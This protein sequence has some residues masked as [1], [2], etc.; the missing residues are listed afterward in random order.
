MLTVMVMLSFVMGGIVTLYISGVRAQTKM[1]D[2]FDAQT[3]LQVGLDRLRKDVHLACTVSTQS[4]SLIQL[5]LSPC[6]NSNEVTWCA[7]GSGSDYGLYRVTSWVSTCTGG[8]KLADFLTSS[9]IFTY[10]APNVT[11][12]TPATGSYALA[13]L[14]VDLTAN[15]V[16][17]DTTTSYHVVD[18]IVFGNSTRCTTGTNCPS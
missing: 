14:H 4:S 16:P 9:S 8:Q 7:R 13:R 10:Y 2:R 3:M 15:E 5:Q 1:S 12:T 18:D 6:D 17:T 11:P